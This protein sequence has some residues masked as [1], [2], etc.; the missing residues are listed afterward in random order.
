MFTAL[1]MPISLYLLIPVTKCGQTASEPLFVCPTCLQ[2]Q[3]FDADV[4][5]KKCIAQGD[6]FC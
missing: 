3:A 2:K 4:P 5:Y 6:A 1:T